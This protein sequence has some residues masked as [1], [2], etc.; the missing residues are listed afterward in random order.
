MRRNNNEWTKYFGIMKDFNLFLLNN[1]LSKNTKKINLNDIIIQK[2]YLSLSLNNIESVQQS[3]ANKS[4][5]T[6]DYFSLPEA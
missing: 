4:E 1:V 6:T 5:A 3:K 2:Q